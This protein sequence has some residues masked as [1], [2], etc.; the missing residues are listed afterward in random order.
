MTNQLYAAYRDDTGIWGVGETMKQA[1]DEAAGYMRDRYA[2]N[3]FVGV[4]AGFKFAFIAPALLAAA[5][6]HRRGGF[7]H[8]RLD[9]ETLVL[10][11]V[12]AAA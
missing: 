9:G 7:R 5:L 6:D 3:E 4:M 11:S 10:T 12:E 8:F 1:L 2:G